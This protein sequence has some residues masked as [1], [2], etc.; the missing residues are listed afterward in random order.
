MESEP[1]YKEDVEKLRGFL[2]SFR[3]DDIDGTPQVKYMVILQMVANRREKMVHIDLDDVYEALGD[4]IGDRMK[5][6]TK[7]YQ[8]LLADAIDEVMPDPTDAQLEEDV[9]DILLRSRLQQNRDGN[10][11]DANDDRQVIPKMLFRRYEVRV[12]PRVKEKAVPLRQVRARMIGNL[13]T[14]K[15]I[16]T[17]VSEVKPHISVATYTCAKGG[18]EVYQEIQGRNFM[19]I[20]QCP[21]QACC[22]ASGRLNLQTRGCKFVKF[23]EV[24]IQEEADEVPVGHV[25]RQLTVHLH[26][27]LTRSCAAGDVVTVSGIFLPVPYSGFRG[28]KAGLIT[29]TYLEAQSVE[30]HKKTLRRLH[31][32]C[33]DAAE[34]RGDAE[35]G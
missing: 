3:E 9:A 32:G 13:L 16:V 27:E 6:N 34:D 17:R 31:A 12:M 19:P 28:M 35:L 25:P 7:R 21:A 10:D 4:E 8:R 29:D 5:D 20:F 30:K 18:F 24:K 23:Q 33:G 15:G 1:D 26:G 22:G 11:Q 2:E 14:V